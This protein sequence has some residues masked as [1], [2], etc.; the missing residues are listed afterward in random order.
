MKRLAFRAVPVAALLVAGLA[1]TR[2]CPG[3]A[4]ASPAP[5]MA[6]GR[7]TRPICAAASTRRST[8]ST[9][10]TSASSKSR[11]GSRP[12]TSV[13]GPRPSSR[14]RRSWSRARCTPPPA[15]AARWSRSTRAPASRSGCTR[16]DEGERATRW[17]P[18]PA[19][20]PRP[21]VLDRRQ[22]RRAHPLCHHRLPPRGAQRQDRPADPR[23][24]HERR[25]RPEGRRHDQRQ[26]GAAI[27]R[28]RRS[29]CTRRRPSSATWPSSA[30]RCSKAWAI[31]YST[32]VKGLVRAFDVR[33]GKKVWQFDTMPGPGQPGHETWEERLV[34]LDRQHRRVDA[35][36]RRPRGRPRLPAGGVAD[37]R[38]VRRQPPR[39]QPLRR[40]PGGGRPE[41]RRSTSGTS[42]SCTTRSGTT[43]CRRRRC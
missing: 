34:G 6:S 30:R 11:G 33:T 2:N 31:V 35:D 21:V 5:R 39:R 9:P 29:A 25:R 32:N 14:A 37:H 19:V 42:S 28:S 43:T 40:K 15:R 26:A 13:R 10:P 20:G 7:T 8:R 1:V 24:R 23:L 18:A 38:R 22:G 17:A 36:H 12:T 3:R 41:D 4:P 16:M 27:S